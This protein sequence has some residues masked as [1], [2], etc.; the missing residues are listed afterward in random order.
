[1]L[2]RA[3]TVERTNSLPRQTRKERVHGCSI[4]RQPLTTKNTSAK[5]RNNPIFLILFQKKP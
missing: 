1:M 4:N 5:M 2:T 3:E